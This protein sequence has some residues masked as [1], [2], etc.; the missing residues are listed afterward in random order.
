MSNALPAGSGGP[1]A[2]KKSGWTI[3]RAA[4]LVAGV[5][6]GLVLL[7]FVAGLLLALVGDAGQNAP[8][9]Q[10]VRDI[11]I[12]ILTLQGI[13]IVGALA[14][15]II[16]IARL[17]NMLQNEVMPILKNTQETVSTA[18]GTVEFVGS[19]LAEPVIRLNGFLA[20]ISVLLRELFGIR[21]AIKRAS[22][23][24]GGHE[25]AD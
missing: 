11:F 24:E 9:V 22:P 14:I 10:I 25:A 20:A 4:A 3:N 23:Q 18:K 15:L 6:I 19:N 1:V 21:R 7:V 13:L 16:Q 5:L 17:I 8:K 12:I 2:A